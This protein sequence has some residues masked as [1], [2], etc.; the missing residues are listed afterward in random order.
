MA[1]WNGPFLR[2][3]IS[4]SDPVYPRNGTMCHCPDIIPNGTDIKKNPNEFIE[5]QW[6]QDV[7]TSTTANRVN[8]I[9]VRGL[10]SSATAMPAE[11]Y[12]YYSP[13]RLLQWPHTVNGVQGWADRPLQTGDGRDY[14]EVLV[15]G[16]A[17]FVT[18][19]AF[20][21][22]PQSLEGDH[23][24]LVGRVQTDRHPNPIPPDLENIDDF[25]K[26]ISEHPDLGWRNVD[27]IV[28]K[29]NA[30]FGVQEY[31]H[32]LQAA[33]MVISLFVTNG[34]DQDYV[35]AVASNEGPNPPID[36]RLDLTGSG[37]E[38]W[39]LRTDIPAAYKTNIRLTYVAA[40]GQ[41][42]PDDLI[43]EIQTLRVAISPDSD[44]AV[45]A[46]PLRT[47]G[48]TAIE[49]PGDLAIPV[50][51]MNYRRTMNSDAVPVAG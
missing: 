37:K 45:Y 38:Q 18:P 23:Y 48:I 6:M 46:K 30:W 14:Q 8:Y 47:L 4:E 21:W 2:F 24:C 15:G 31:N 5:S 39:N 20:E 43:V 42:I 10:N 9:Y 22:Q 41:P 17:K 34:R 19:S 13:A 51:V 40:S 26:Y 44:L 33:E 11:I 29:D 3:E 32:G 25:A 1:V 36:M 16:K 35:T 50:G 12:L 27:M 7:G 49:K 28:P